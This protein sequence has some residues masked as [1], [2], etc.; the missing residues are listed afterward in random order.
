[1]RHAL[2]A[3]TLFSLCACDRGHSDPRSTTTPT[4]TPTTTTT[5]T[6]T[7]TP[8]PTPAWRGTYKSLAGT[9]YLPPEL[10]VSWKPVETTAGIGEGTLSMTI[11]P[12]TGR[13]RGLLEGVLGPAAF[14]GLSADGKLTATIVRKD[15]GDHGFAGTLAGT[16][17]ADKAEGTMTLSP[18]EGGA[19]RSATFALS[20]GGVAEAS[21]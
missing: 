10:K 9:L 7:S 6:S 4:T 18:A 1:M 11:D 16:I 14:T 12:V 2:L 5:S 19:I 21:L 17:G 3:W 8:T 13:V 15:P 20:S